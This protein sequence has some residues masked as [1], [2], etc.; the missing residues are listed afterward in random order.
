MGGRSM[1]SEGEC[2]LVYEFGEFGWLL[3]EEG[4]ILV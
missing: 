1:L 4:G 3:G 2:G